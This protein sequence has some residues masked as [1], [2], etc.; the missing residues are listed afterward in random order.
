[1]MYVNPIGQPHLREI[2]AGSFEGAR[3]EQ[4]LE[5]LEHFFIFTLMKEMRKSINESGLFPHDPSL[6][7]YEEMLDDA[8]SRNMAE[9]GQFGIAKMME[10]QLRIQEMQRE[11]QGE[12]KLDSTQQVKAKS[13]LADN[14]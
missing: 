14:Q 4:A 2:E 7:F 8:L 9:S 11:I 1:M 13:D 5:D 6:D 12:V 3:R 10:E